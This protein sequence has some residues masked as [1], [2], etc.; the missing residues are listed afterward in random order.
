M[1][2]TLADYVDLV[3]R[4]YRWADP[5]H[6]FA[7]HTSL[8]QYLE[9]A[10]VPSEKIGEP[11]DRRFWLGE[12]IDEITRAARKHLDAGSF[13]NY[14][15]ILDEMR[16]TDDHRWRLAA[17][18]RAPLPRAVARFKNPPKSVR[19]QEVVATVVK[20]ATT[21]PRVLERPEDA[22]EAIQ[23]MI[24][25]RANEVFFVLFV[26][27]RNVVVGYVEMTEGNPIGVGVHPY[28]IFREAM[29]VNGAAFITAHQHPTGNPDPS[30]EDR[31]L[32]DRLRTAGQI[33]GIPCLDNFVLGEQR[34]YSE[35][36][37]YA[38]PYPKKAS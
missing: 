17:E 10:G 20:S 36:E 16:K 38:K 29:L 31:A 21:T 18:T 35:T 1:T 30:D 13:R 11:V 4:A 7:A 6:P 27:I 12:V 14:E 37:G 26:N 2:R 19:L 23:E 5:Y 25:Q 24:G 3:D 33:M 34:W 28:G 8:R 32:W 9:A 15:Q 22:I